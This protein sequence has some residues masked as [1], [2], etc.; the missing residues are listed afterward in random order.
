ML[1]RIVWII[2]LSCPV[3]TL[4]VTFINI[5]GWWGGNYVDIMVGGALGIWVLGLPIDGRLYELGAV[6]TFTGV[7]EW[8][9]VFM[10]LG[11][12][13]KLPD[14]RLSISVLIILSFTTEGL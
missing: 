1:G 5:F 3:E 8:L 4:G 10:F 12:Y 7:F 9:A 14:E 2:L 13:G 11:G 6:I